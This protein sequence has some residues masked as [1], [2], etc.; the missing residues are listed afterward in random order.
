MFKKIIPAVLGSA[1]ALSATASAA[2]ELALG[3]FM[4]PNHPMNAAVFTPFAESLAEVSDGEM[5]VR[6]FPGGALNSSPPKQYSALLSGVMDVGFALPGYTAELFP[7]TTVI[8]SPGLCKSAEDCTEA[9]LRAKS[10]IEAEYDAK[11]L[12]VWAND[13]PI[14]LTRDRPVRSVEDMAGLKTRVTTAADVPYLKAIGAAPVSQPV[15]VINQNL[16]NGVIDAIVIDPGSIRSFSL[17]EPANYVTTGLPLSGAAFVLL[18]N[19]GVWDGLSEQ[20]KA[21]VEEASGDTLSRAG[22]AAY[23][24]AGDAGLELAKQSGVEVIELDDEARAAFSDAMAAPFESFRGS[25]IGAVT[26][27]EIYDVMKGT[28][29]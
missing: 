6:L 22:G 9:L 4:G 1:L 12:A 27:G 21:W 5:S 25:P 19:K 26:G 15:S 24:A 7:V 29:G 28:E 13:P 23:G 2:Q 3:Y 8:S 18:M 16:S 14:L 17:H 20:Q 11:L 10:Q